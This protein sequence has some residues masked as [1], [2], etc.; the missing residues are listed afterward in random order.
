[1]A[2]SLTGH[3]VWQFNGRLAGGT[4]RYLL[5][6]YGEMGTATLNEWQVRCS[7]AASAQWSGA[8]Y[9]VSLGHQPLCDQKE[10]SFPRRDALSFSQPHH[11]VHLPVSVDLRPVPRRPIQRVST[12]IGGSGSVARRPRLAYAPSITAKNFSSMT[13]P[14]VERCARA[15]TA[16]WAAST[17]SLP[18]T[19]KVVFWSSATTFTL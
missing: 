7:A 9:V 14:S 12:S 15:A 2:E 17:M 13:S 10:V 19:T 3:Q 1:V 5:Q 4:R 11:A 8:V 16:F 6:P 18:T